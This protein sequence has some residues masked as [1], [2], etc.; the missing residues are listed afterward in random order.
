MGMP[1]VFSRTASASS[2]SSV[3]F[4]TLTERGEDPR[5]VDFPLF[6]FR[7]TSISPLGVWSKSVTFPTP[8]VLN[9]FTMASSLE[10]SSPSMYFIFP[11]R[12]HSIPCRK[13]VF[14]A[15]L[16]PQ[17]RLRPGPSSKVFLH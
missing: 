14:P 10:N 11:V 8:D 12:H 5:V 3:L 1:S 6:L 9:K 13:L 16:F 2:S 17:R 15:P 4:P 7:V